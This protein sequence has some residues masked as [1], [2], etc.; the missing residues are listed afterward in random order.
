M[1]QTKK[2]KIKFKRSRRKFKTKKKTQLRPIVPI[3]ANRDYTKRTLTP[4]TIDYKNV[5]LLRRYIS[6]QGKIL[7]RRI[8][9][10][11]AKK[12]RNMSRAIKNA[13]ILGLIPF[14]RRAAHQENF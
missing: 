2:I 1:I 8:S 11:T 7:P 12:Q 14:V 3:L 5:V 13:R 4:G 9:G 10:L 6:S